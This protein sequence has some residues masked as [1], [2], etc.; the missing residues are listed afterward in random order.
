MHQKGKN[1]ERRIS[2]VTNTSPMLP[3]NLCSH[4][5]DYRNAPLF[6]RKHDLKCN[7]IQP[8]E[9]VTVHSINPNS[10]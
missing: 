9:V 5:G 7:P 10:R 1:I 3:L 6:I 2:K 4:R 8:K